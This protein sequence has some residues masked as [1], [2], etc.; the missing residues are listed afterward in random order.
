MRA[1]LTVVE[2]ATRELREAVLFASFHAGDRIVIASPI[3][4]TG[5]VV[6]VFVVPR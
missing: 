3:S 2:D 1:A 6:V 5:S 4:A